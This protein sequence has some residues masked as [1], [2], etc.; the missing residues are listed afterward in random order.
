MDPCQP[1]HAMVAAGRLVQAVVMLLCI[2]SA[3][4]GT[5]KGLLAA[6]GPEGMRDWE[7]SRGACRRDAATVCFLCSPQVAVDD[8]WGTIL[9]QLLL[10]NGVRVSDSESAADP[11]DPA[12]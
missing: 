4:R 7:G 9:N 6:S 8:S 11:C 3:G 1:W 2:G 10:K 5:R 12:Y